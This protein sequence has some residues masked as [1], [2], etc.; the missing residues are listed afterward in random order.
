MVWIYRGIRSLFLITASESEHIHSERHQC[1]RVL[2]LVP[3]C[4]T[5][6]HNYPYFHYY[7]P[8]CEKVYN[9]K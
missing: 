1:M 4:N 2:A 6:L 8:V 9:H 5:I 3:D 7:A